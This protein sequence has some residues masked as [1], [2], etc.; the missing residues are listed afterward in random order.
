VGTYAKTWKKPTA[1]GALIMDLPRGILKLCLFAGLSINLPRRGGWD[2]VP[3]NSVI[4]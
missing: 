3:W 2:L 1:E 4:Y